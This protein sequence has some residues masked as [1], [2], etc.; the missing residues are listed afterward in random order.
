[1]YLFAA[2]SKIREFILRFSLKVSFTHV[3]RE[4]NTESDWL[5]NEALRQGGRV[6]LPTSDGLVE[7]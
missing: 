1:M 6:E 7:N 2:I 3:P 5:Y 4:Q